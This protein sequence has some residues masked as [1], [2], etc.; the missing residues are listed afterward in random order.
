LSSPTERTITVS[1]IRVEITL[2]PKSTDNPVLRADFRLPVSG[3]RKRYS[4]GTTDITQAAREL[5]ALLPA[6]T[7]DIRK[8]IAAGAARSHDLSNP[9]PRISELADWYTQT[10]MPFMGS[11]PPT[12]EKAVQVLREFELWAKAHNIGRV[13]QISMSRI[14]EFAAWGDKQRQQGIKPKGPRAPKTVHNH[15]AQLRSWLLAAVNAGKLDQSPIKKWLLPNVPE[16]EVAVLSR[17]E[18]LALIDAVKE[19]QADYYAPIAL[20]AHTGLRIADVI[21]LRKDQV[22][23]D[24]IVRPQNKV[25][26]AVAIPITPS[27]RAALSA[28]ISSGN[29]PKAHVCVHPRLRAPFRKNSLLRAVQRA[30]VL[31]KLEFRPTIKIL[32]AS[33]ATFL[34][35]SGC[36][37]KVLMELMGHKNLETTLKFYVRAGFDAAVSFLAQLEKN[38]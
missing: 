6:I 33:W 17:G 5:D 36:P 13:S 26:R 15:V 35:E 21:D 25:T 29:G 1:G 28:A 7:Q 10:H 8:D 18:V 38:H 37:P 22:L 27:I 2:R 11:K 20:A 31:A 16:K 9:D 14:Q 12:I 19:H 4:T 30:A 23:A 24:R 34:A 3:K 32:R